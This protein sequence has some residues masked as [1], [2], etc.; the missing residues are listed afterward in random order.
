MFT[1]IPESIILEAIDENYPN[2]LSEEMTDMFWDE[3]VELQA[4]VYGDK[5]SYIPYI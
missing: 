4:I 2:S 1:P 5:E 3:D